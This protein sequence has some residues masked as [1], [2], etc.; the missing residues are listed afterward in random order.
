MS[1]RIS[2]SRARRTGSPIVRAASYD[3]LAGRTTKSV[4]LVTSSDRK[5]AMISVG[6]IVK[7]LHT[8]TSRM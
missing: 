1:R 2:S 5:T 4:R 8:S 3:S 7:M 6:V